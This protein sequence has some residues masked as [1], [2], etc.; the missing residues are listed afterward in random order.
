MAASKQKAQIFGLIS[1]LWNATYALGS[2]GFENPYGT[3]LT[4][5]R[6]HTHTHTRARAP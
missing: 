4:R 2:T 6:A 1:A 3:P 5:A